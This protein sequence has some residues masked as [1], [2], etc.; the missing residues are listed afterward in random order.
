MS[1]WPKSLE[2]W[3]IGVL[4]ATLQQR[5]GQAHATNKAIVRG[6][7]WLG[8]FVLAAKGVAAAK[9]VAVAWRYG[10]S[11]VLEGYLLVFTLASW[12]ISLFAAATRFVLVPTLVRLRQ[13]DAAASSQ[14]QRQITAWVWTMAVGITILTAIALSVLLETGW[15]GLTSAGR[16]AARDALP[17]MAAMVG[18]G[19]VAAWHACQL[20]SVQRHANTF[21]EAMP[22]L[23][24]LI[25]V[26]LW[27]GSG[28][29]PLLWG[30]VMGFAAQAVL[31]AWAVHVAGMPV[32]PGSL[33]GRP[34]SLSM[35]ATAYWLLAAQ[36]LMAAAGVLDQ[37]ILA[38]LP[39]GSLAAYAYANRL[40]AL[41][42]SLS[43]LVLGR[44]ML[45]VLAAVANADETYSLA[46]GWAKRMCWA[47]VAGAV[48]MVLL[49]YPA[50]EL[51]FERGA[52]TSQDTAAVAELLVLLALQLP[53]YLV[54][55]VWVQWALTRPEHA[56]ALWWAAVASVLTK[57]LIMLSLIALLDWGAS[58]VA[59]ALTASTIAYWWVLK[60]FVRRD[61]DRFASR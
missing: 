42:L 18:L 39:T 41:V 15:L 13:E 47:G 34:F 12:P 40:M 43:S 45:P 60:R 1:S 11:G 5:L 7:I 2:R 17:W 14:W 38:H 55:T 57:L 59:L 27:P 35:R 54:G 21:L 58:A 61:R 51:L 25:A 37:I 56:P 16:A 26:V 19:M 6:M 46:R 3:L 32:A 49:A 24:I 10:T 48:F 22:A 20:M 36:G 52:F 50:V 23:A 29:P 28:M 8:L 9:E 53:L 31:V 44:A 4:P 30:T 33:S